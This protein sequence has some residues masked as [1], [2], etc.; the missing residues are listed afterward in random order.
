MKRVFFTI[1]LAA[2]VVAGCDTTDTGVIGPL[3]WTS[4]NMTIEGTDDCEFFDPNEML[5]FEMVINGSDVTMADPNSS[6]VVSTDDYSPTDN[7][8]VLT[9]AGTVDTVPMDRM[10]PCV[11]GLEEELT[12]TLD[13]PDVSLDQNETVQVTWDHREEDISANLGDCG[14]NVWFVPL[15]CEDQATFTLTQDPPPQ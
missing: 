13:D 11:V 15:P 1:A 6:L 12:L 2:T 14:N 3:T 8:V 10:P 5:T 9:G 4:S 7:V